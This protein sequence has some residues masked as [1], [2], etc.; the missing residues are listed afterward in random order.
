LTHVICHAILPILRAMP[1]DKGAAVLNLDLAARKR[2]WLRKSQRE[3]AEEL[4]VNERTFGR[5]E[6]GESTPG[7]AQLDRWARALDLSLAD[8]LSEPESAEVVNG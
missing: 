1:N 3:M 7:L 4:G 6:R 5:W 2:G 8:L